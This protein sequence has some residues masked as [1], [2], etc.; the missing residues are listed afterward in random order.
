MQAWILRYGEDADN[1]PFAWEPLPGHLSKAEWVDGAGDVADT[2]EVTVHGVE[3][4]GDVA[5]LMSSRLSLLLAPPAA[6]S[7]DDLL[8]FGPYDV[9]PASV[10]GEAA[11]WRLAGRIGAHFE[12]TLSD[13]DDEDQ[14]YA[15]LDTA[16]N[17]TYSWRQPWAGWAAGAGAPSADDAEAYQV[18]AEFIYDQVVAQMVNAENLAGARQILAEWGFTAVPYVA[19]LTPTG[20]KHR[21]RIEPLYRHADVG[22]EVPAGWTVRLSSLGVPS[23]FAAASAL[24]A[25]DLSQDYLDAH[26]GIEFPDGSNRPGDYR[27]RQ[28]AAVHRLFGENLSDNVLLTAGLRRPPVYLSPNTGLG[29]LKQREEVERWKLQNEA[30]TLTAVRRFYPDY[31]DAARAFV[32]PLQLVTLA[33]EQLPDP[34][35]PTV[36]QVRQVNHAWDGEEGYRQTIK[37][38]LWQGGFWRT[39]GAAVKGLTL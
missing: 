16:I 22:Y 38:S 6:D 1:V 19:S 11:V 13:S 21:P 15:A 29:L 27:N 30:A 26:P 31:T 10:D 2:C 3:T 36:W 28:I 8:C 14:F 37:A 12:A 34:S 25:F 9:E 39:S 23:S 24:S 18:S 4:A 33:T 7:V 17:T 35:L 20:Y 5:K 32:T